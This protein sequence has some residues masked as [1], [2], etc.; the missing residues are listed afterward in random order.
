MDLVTA[1][2]IAYLIG[3]VS[4]AVLVSRAFGL[5]DPR[6]YG[7]G[8]PGATNVLRTGRRAAATLTFLGDAL[9]GWFA[10]TV[11]QQHVFAE[12]LAVAV[13]AVAVVVGHVWPLYFRFAGGKGVSTTLGVLAALDGWLAA[14]AA[15]TWGIIALYFRISSLAGLVAAAF[16][17]FFA[18]FLYGMGR[19][20]LEPALAVT[21]VALLLAWRHVDNIRKLIAGTE[22]KIGSSSTGSPQ[23]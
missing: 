9:K 17:T 7:S 20:A 22:G 14:G 23:G 16:A 4:F 2:L 3:S 12:P 21:V 10:V 13:A 15:A 8:N 1:A 11:V 18:F 19:F 5:P 6:S